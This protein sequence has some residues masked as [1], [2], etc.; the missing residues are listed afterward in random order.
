MPTPFEVAKKLLKE[1][2]G[3]TFEHICEFLGERDECPPD[4]IKARYTCRDCKPCAQ[5]WRE[6]CERKAAEKEIDCG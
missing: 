2:G 3:L 4:C 1:R 6:Y 5:C